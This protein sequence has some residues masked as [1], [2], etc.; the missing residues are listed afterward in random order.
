MTIQIPIIFFFYPS[1]SRHLLV[2]IPY[3]ICRQLCGFILFNG[4]TKQH[5]SLYVICVRQ[6]RDLPTT[7][8]L[9]FSYLL[10]CYLSI[11]G[12]FTHKKVPM[13]HKLTKDGKNKNSPSSLSE[14][15]LTI[16]TLFI[17]I[18]IAICLLIKMI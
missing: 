18:F 16:K 13:T 6:V 7:S 9:W 17:P 3:I 8:F 2:F 11:L 10:P 1:R 5:I 12:T 4:L 14:L 15:K